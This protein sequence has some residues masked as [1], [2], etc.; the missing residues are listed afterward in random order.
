MPCSEPSGHERLFR[1]RVAASS[2]ASSAS[3][4]RQLSPSMLMISEWW[5]SRSMSAVVQAAFGKIVGQ[6]AN[7]RFE[8]M[9]ML[10]R[11]YRRETTWN[12]RSAFRL[13]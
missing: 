3:R 1:R 6:S 5:T 13:S 9:T 10:F 4:L 2:L 12:S 8:V 11:S 7:A